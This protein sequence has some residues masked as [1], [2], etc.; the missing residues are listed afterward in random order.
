[1]TKK[2]NFFPYYADLLSRGAK[3]TTIRITNRENFEE[4]DLIDV[5]IGWSVEES[6]VL[7]SARITAV[8]SKRIRELTSSDFDGESPDCQEPYPTALVLGAIYRKVVGLDDIVWVIKF[9]YQG[10]SDPEA[11]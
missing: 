11:Q 2:L 5:T 8:Y 4:G 1:M 6:K 10:A 7:K 9:E 3:T